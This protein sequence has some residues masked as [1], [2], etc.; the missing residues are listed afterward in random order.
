MILL[1]KHPV[2]RWQTIAVLFFAVVYSLLSLVNH[3]NFRTYAFDHGLMLNAAWD[4]AHFRANDCMLIQ[5]PLNN[6]LSE[7]FEIVIMALSPFIFVFGTYTLLIFQILFVLF[8]GYGVFKFVK[9]V[10]DD[11]SL[12]FWAQMHFY[13]FFG[14]YSALNFDFHN[15]VIGAMLVPWFFYFFR[16]GRWKWTFFYFILILLSKENMSLWMGFIGLGLALLH[17][18]EAGMRNTALFFSAISFVVFVLLVKWIMPSLANQGEAYIQIRQNY[19]ALGSSL[20]EIFLNML[21][22]PLRVLK[23]LF[24]NHSGDIRGNFTKLESYIYVLLSG[25]ILLIIR[26]QFLVMLIPIVAQ[27]MFHND[28]LKWG[29]G[30]HYSIEMAPICSMGAFYV[31]S[32]SFHDNWKK[33]LGWTMAALSMVMSVRS[34]D[35]SSTY[36]DRD[37]HRVYQARHYNK[38]YDVKEANRALNMI[39]ADAPVCAQSPFVPHLALRDKV[40]QFPFKEEADYVVL[41]ALENPYPL[42]EQAFNDSIASMK[43]S[44]G[45]EVIYEKNSMLIFRRR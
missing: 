28:Y 34:F 45:W 1:F 37:R 25:G 16:T 6:Y 41:S 22:D 15:N 29:I 43:S 20:S 13:F 35:R 30:D 4:Y 12:G 27:K 23:L 19:S 26:P 31:I 38:D 44:G 2:R 40:W 21:T 9:E 17:R 3:Y 11:E 14:I 42:E 7:H 8:G 10:S 39:P 5:P 36:F 24:I 33:Y 18:A 32:V